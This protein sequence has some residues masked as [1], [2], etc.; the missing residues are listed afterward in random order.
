MSIKSILL[1]PRYF[2]Y[3][4]NYL[5]YRLFIFPAAIR[6]VLDLIP[7]ISF[8]PL[9]AVFKFSITHRTNFC[10]WV[11]SHVYII[12]TFIYNQQEKPTF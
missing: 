11:F 10:F 3:L 2:V 7:H 9:S 8:A 5:H 1:L 12:N 4:A 6:T